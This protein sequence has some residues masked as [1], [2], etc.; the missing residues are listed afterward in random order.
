MIPFLPLEEILGAI[1][2]GV[3][4][5]VA[6]ISLYVLQKTFEKK[7][8]KRDMARILRNEIKQTLNIVPNKERERTISDENNRLPDSRIYS[9]L[10]QTGNIRFFSDNLQ[11]KLNEWYSVIDNY[12]FN[13]DADVGIE[14]IQDLEDMEHK[15]R[16]FLMMLRLNILFRK[17]TTIQVYLQCGLVFVLAA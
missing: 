8:S 7:A 16:A 4:I 14:I 9:G 2:R 10:L 3:V 5:V 11:S 6:G 12:W 15:N 17:K 13:D 1:V